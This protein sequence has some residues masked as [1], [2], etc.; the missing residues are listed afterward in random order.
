MQA[1]EQAGEQPVAGHRVEDARLPVEGRQ[2]RGRQPDDG[3]ELDRR[4]EAAEPDRVDRP[5]D[6]V[7]D[8]EVAI[9]HEAG[10][11]RGHRDVESRADRQRADQPDRR[12]ALGIAA[13]AGRGGHG[14]EADEGE[15]HHRRPAQHTAPAVGAERARVRGHERVPQLR[16]QMHRADPDEGQDDRDLDPH[17]HGVD[18]RGLAGAAHE[19]RGERQHDRHGGQV[20]ES[21]VARR[22]GQRGRE[23]QAEIGSQRL[24]VAGPAHRDG[25]RGHG[26]FQHEVP[27]DDPGR[28]DAEAG[29]GVAVGRARLRDHRGELGV[30]QPDEGAGDAADHEGE[31]QRRPGMLRGGGPRQHEDAGADRGAQPDADEA[32]GGE[33]PGEACALLDRRGGGNGAGIGHRRALFRV[34]RPS[35]QIP[36]RECRSRLVIVDRP[37]ARSGPRRR[38]PRPRPAACRCGRPRPRAP[39]DG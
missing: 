25:R 20:H 32:G 31:G 11:H 6:R 3:P 35:R 9:G 39:R 10:E 28:Q 12:V 18:Q 7:G 26:E 33:A 23:A 17:E 37:P 24:R 1:G 15:E 16:P 8:V 22:A 5:G 34:R 30:A 19:Q 29:A 14:L 4:R 38:D 2:R 21:A 27:A 36:R 13:L